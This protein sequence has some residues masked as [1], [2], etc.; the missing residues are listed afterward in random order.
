[1]PPKIPDTERDQIIAAIRA[2]GTCRGIASDFGRAPSTIAKIAKDEGLDGAFERTQTI[3][4]TRARQADLANLRSQLA[5]R[6][7]QRAHKILDRL[8]ADTFVTKTATVTGD[9]VTIK[10][11]D[12]APRDERDLAAAVS[13]YT[14]A[15]DRVTDPGDS[16][17][18]AKSLLGGL[19]EALRVAAG[20]LDTDEPGS[21]D[22][23]AES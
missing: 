14:T 15:A 6:T 5:L 13:S 17:A 18:A 3:H 16:S 21:S 23:P 1:M 11:K 2:G 8:D 19:G 4:A 7:Y 22:P 9:I 12:P 20:R 10:T